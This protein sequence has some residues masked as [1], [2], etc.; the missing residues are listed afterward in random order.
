M[1]P[2]SSCPKRACVGKPKMV[3]YLRSTKTVAARKPR[4]RGCFR[5]QRRF[6]S[7][8][9]TTASLDERTLAVFQRPERLIRGNRCADLVVVPFVLRF[10][11]LLH[12]DQIR[13]VDLAPVDPD[14]ALA[15]QR[16]VGRHLL[17]LG[18]HL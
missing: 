15:E 5:S 2:I 8:F 11:G 1:S 14:A 12:F 16:V 3:I 6:A 18:D 13:R 17:H 7:C 4:W 9:R 10:G